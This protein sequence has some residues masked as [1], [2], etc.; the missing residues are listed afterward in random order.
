MDS[1]SRRDLRHR[2]TRLWFRAQLTALSPLPTV[3]T[4]ALP[5]SRLF[6]SGISEERSVRPPGSLS[7]E[8]GTGERPPNDLLDRNRSVAKPP[9]GGRRYSE[10]PHPQRRGTE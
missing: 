2:G 7:V 4:L 6:W 3:L 5:H 1:G 9:R 8:R 10:R